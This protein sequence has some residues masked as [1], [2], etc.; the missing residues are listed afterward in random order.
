VDG[1]RVYIMGSRGDV[2]CLDINGRRT[3]TTGRSPTSRYMVDTRTFPN[4]P[5]RFA[6]AE[7]PAAPEPIA[8]EPGDADI[9]WRYDVLETLDVWPQDAVDCSILVYG[10]YLYVCACNGVDRSHKNIPRPTR[11]I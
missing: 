9:V 3:A 2:L 4:K 7:A 10:D 8:L 1:D 11:P 5:G 6:P